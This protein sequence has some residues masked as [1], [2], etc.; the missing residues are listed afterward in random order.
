M[1]PPPAGYAPT[2]DKLLKSLKGQ[3]LEAS[4][5][6]LLSLLKRRQVKGDACA[7]ATAHILLQVV[8]KSKWR[9]VDQLLSNVQRVGTRL[10]RAAPRELVIGNIVRRV[11]GLIRDEAS[12]DRNADE[13]GNDS[14]PDL[15][16]LPAG[17][18]PVPARPGPSP[19][20]RVPS[21]LAPGSFN[22][23]KSMFNLLSAPDPA[24]SVTASGTST[25]LAQPQAAS[26]RAL[27][28]E[29]IDGIEEIMDEITQVDDQ[30]AG[31][32]DVQIQPGD[33]V[34]VYQPSPSVER[35]L[36]RAATKRQFTVLIASIVV[37]KDPSEVPHA[38]LR[39]KLG[40]AGSKVISLASSG[41]MAYMPRVNKVI[42]GA[43]A[44]VADGG[45]LTEGGAGIIARAA[46]EQSTPVIVLAGVYKLCPETPYDLDALVEV[47]DAGAFVN[48]AEGT[49]VNGVNVES[50]VTEFIQPELIDL[51]ITNLGPYT[52][53]HLSDVMADHYKSEDI[54]WDLR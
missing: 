11:L 4:I 14:V 16:S 10:V 40:A 38:S 22:V 17:H 49:V 3:S 2:L 46:H 45:V 44:V 1:A 8:A 24:E 39:K 30:I 48:Y 5:E 29:V 50:P 36:A 20:A 35:F 54:D 34:L 28:S 19:L 43:R 23:A 41:A 6:G 13:F 33:Y 51:Y 26:T 18:T 9:D 7:T 27:R 12:E 31:F 37:P 25:P 53:H 32:A 15:Q 21:V 52:R 42:L 47:G